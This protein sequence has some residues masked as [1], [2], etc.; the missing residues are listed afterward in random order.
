MGKITENYRIPAGQTTFYSVLSMHVRVLCETPTPPLF[1]FLGGGVRLLSGQWWVRSLSRLCR[2][3]AIPPALS[4]CEASIP[5]FH[6][7]R[8]RICA[9]QTRDRRQIP[10]VLRS[11][12]PHRLLPCFHVLSGLR[13]ANPLIQRPLGDSFTTMH[14]EWIV[15]RLKGEEVSEQHRAAPDQRPSLPE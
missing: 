15:C 2:Q 12:F 3:R 4:S 13:A 9:L 6:L 8:R 5:S 7:P 11:P 10:P 1:F 14:N